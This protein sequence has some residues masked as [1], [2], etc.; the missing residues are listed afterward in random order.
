[1]GLAEQK[2]WEKDIDIN[3]AWGKEHP[4]EIGTTWSNVIK[5]RVQTRI[6][7]VLI[8]RSILDRITNIK[9]ITKVSDYDV[10][11]WLREK[12]LQYMK[13]PY[14]KIPTDMINNPEFRQKVKELYKEEKEKGIERYKLFRTRC[15]EMAKKLKKHIAQKKKKKKLNVLKRIDEIRK[16]SDGQKVQ[17][18][19]W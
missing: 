8:D 15:V 10:A 12:I 3:D 17:I 19:K 9:I 1:M 16:C 6:Y 13:I 4:N 5:K 14:D 2:Q 7:R 18:S 11:A